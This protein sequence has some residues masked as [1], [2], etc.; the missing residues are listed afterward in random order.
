LGDENGADD[1]SRT[2]RHFH[3]PLQ[4]F[5]LDHLFCTLDTYSIH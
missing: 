5:L 2:D 1:T 3:F 4:L